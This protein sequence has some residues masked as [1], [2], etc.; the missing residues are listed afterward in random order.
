MNRKQ[1]KLFAVACML[2]DHV[3]RIFPLYRLFTPLS[4]ALWAAGWEAT[5]DWV[6][7]DLSFCLMFIGRLAAPVFVYGIAVGFLHTHDVK[8]YLRRL[9]VTAVIAQVPYTLFDLAEMRRCYDLAG[10]WRDTGLNILFTLALGLAA[11]ALWEYCRRHN[12]LWLGLL[13]VAGAAGLARLLHMEGKE[14]YIL[15]IFVFYLTR[16]LSRPQRALLFIPAVLLSRWNLVRWALSELSAGAV[17]NC[18]LNVFGNYLGMLVTLAD[19]GKPGQAGRAFQ[20]GMYAFYPLHFAVLALT[21]FLLPP[22]A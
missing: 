9:L 14:G 11:L 21:G 20:Y 3:V 12:R 1:L 2:F 15:L 18:F 16:N 19:N 10:D 4:D 6:L 13:A 7:E 5:S 22:L 8:R 17:R